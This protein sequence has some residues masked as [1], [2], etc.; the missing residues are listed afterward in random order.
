MASEFSPR[1]ARELVHV[2]HYPVA[3]SG[4]RLAVC[5]SVAPCVRRRESE[6]SS[7]A[8]TGCATGSD[9]DMTAQIRQSAPSAT[10]CGDVALELP[11]W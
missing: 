6:P 8:T 11:V 2:F 5:C 9:L 10:L 4:R 7:D 1:E 3:N